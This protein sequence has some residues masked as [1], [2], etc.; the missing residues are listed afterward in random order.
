MMKM[1]LWTVVGLLMGLVVIVEIGL[2][3]RYGFGNPLLYTT[4]PEIGYLIAPNQRTRRNGNLIEINEYS[5]RSQGVTAVPEVKTLRVLMVGDSIL[6]GGWWTDQ[7]NTISNLIAQG[8]KQKIP[9]EFTQAEVLNASANSWGPR[10]E[11]AYLRKFGNFGAQIIILVI[12]TDDLFAIAPYSVVV[13][14]DRNYPDRKPGLALV[15]VYQRYLQKPA[16]I[17]ELAK[18][19]QEPGDRV[20]INLEAIKH[21]HEFAIAH[22]SRFLLIMTPLKRELGTPGPRDYEFKARERLQTFTNQENIPYIDVL[23]IFNHHP[24]PETLYHD[25]IHLNVQGNML[26]RDILTAKIQELFV[27]VSSH[28]PWESSSANSYK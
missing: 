11:L 22:Q 25:H 14:R 4:D 8:L 17:P 3:S 19:Q 26:I 28:L 7:S 23:P 21:I 6:N 18:L 12:N 1:I 10:N 20:G 15:E 13:G 16:A 2:R 27:P 9:R 24:Q 5:M